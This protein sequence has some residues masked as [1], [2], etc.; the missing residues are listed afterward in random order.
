MLLGKITRSWAELPREQYDQLRLELF[1]ALARFSAGPK[2]VL[3]QLCR[4]LVGVAFNTMP[5]QWPNAIVTSIHTL[6]KATQ[7]VPVSG[8]VCSQ[9]MNIL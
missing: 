4:A 6:R 9:E 1:R 5:E 8:G 2:L 7:D 3:N